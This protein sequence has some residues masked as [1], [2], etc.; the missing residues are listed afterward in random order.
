MSDPK[1]ISFRM[2]QKKVNALDAI[3]A[4]TQRDRTY[5]LNEAVDAYL[6]LAEYH[7]QLVAAG[8]KDAQEGR[9]VEQSEMR[10]K[11]ERLERLEK[12]RSA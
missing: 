6:D 11:L 3:A 10:K 7:Q 4:R 12:R 1:T 5:L 9:Y 8:I 2:E